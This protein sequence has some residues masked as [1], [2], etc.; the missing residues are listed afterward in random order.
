MKLPAEVQIALRENL[1]SMSHARS[2]INLEN[3]SDQIKLL[4]EILQNELTVRE[5]EQKVKQAKKRETKNQRQTFAR[6]VLTLFS[7]KK[8]SEELNTPV[9]L[10]KGQ[11]RKGLNNY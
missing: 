6:K 11:Q 4:K 10:K 3:R 1:I 7:Q 8:L 2:I 5:I 9:V